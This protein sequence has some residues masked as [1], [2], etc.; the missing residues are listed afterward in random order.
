MVRMHVHI[1]DCINQTL[2]LSTFGGPRLSLSL[3][4]PRLD[5][6]KKVILFIYYIFVILLDRKVRKESSED[7]I[8]YILF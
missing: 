2:F 8:H 6:N 1:F 5:L 7:Q 4:P 3:S